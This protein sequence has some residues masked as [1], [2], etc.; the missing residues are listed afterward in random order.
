MPPSDMEVRITGKVANRGLMEEKLRAQGLSVAPPRQWEREARETPSVCSSSNGTSSSTSSPAKSSPVSVQLQHL[1]QMQQPQQQPHIIQSQPQPQ[2]HIHVLTGSPHKVEQPAARYATLEAVPSPNKTASPAFGAPMVVTRPADTVNGVRAQPVRVL[3]VVTRQQAQQQQQQQQQQSP[4]E[5]HQSPPILEVSPANPLSPGKPGRDAGSPSALGADPILTGKVDS[6]LSLPRLSVQSGYEYCSEGVSTP[7]ESPGRYVQFF[8]SAYDSAEDIR[9]KTFVVPA[10]TVCMVSSC[11]AMFTSARA[12]DG[13]HATAAGV[14]LA[15]VSSLFALIAFKV[16]RVSVKQVVSVFCFGCVLAIVLIDLMSAS[17]LGVRFW[18]LSVMLL[19]LCLSVNTSQYVDLSVIAIVGVSLAVERVEAMTRFGLYDAATFGRGEEIDVCNCSD[20]PCARP[21]FQ[22]ISALLGSMMTFV[23]DYMVTRGFARNMRKQKESVAAAVRL[24]EE[25]AVVLSHYETE[26]GKR[27]LHEHPDSAALPNRLGKALRMIVNNL[28]VYRR[29]LPPSILHRD[30][31]LDTEEMDFDLM[32]GSPDGDSDRENSDSNRSKGT[33][34]SD[35]GRLSAIVVPA[36][37]IPGAGGLQSVPS[38]PDLLFIPP[39][40][41]AESQH[42]SKQNKARTDSQPNSNILMT[43]MMSRKSAFSSSGKDD[44]LGRSSRSRLRAASSPNIPESDSKSPRMGVGRVESQLREFR[45]RQRN[46]ALMVAHLDASRDLDEPSLMTAI[47]VFVP[48]V[49]KQVVDNGGVILSISTSNSGVRVLATWNVYKRCPQQYNAS[50]EAV[51][52]AVSELSSLEEF[53]PPSVV[54]AFAVSAGPVSFANVGSDLAM[55]PVICGLPVQ[56][57][58]ALS[59]LALQLGCRALCDDR[60]YQHVRSDIHARPIDA[61]VMLGA[62]SDFTVYEVL[63]DQPAFLSE[64][65]SAFSELRQGNHAE[66]VA[67]YEHVLRQCIVPDKQ[68]ARL[69]KVAQGLLTLVPGGEAYCREEMKHRFQ[70]FKSE[71]SPTCSPPL[72]PL[73]SP[74]AVDEK[75]KKGPSFDKKEPVSTGPKEDVRS[76]SLLRREESTDV[77]KLRQHLEDQLVTGASTPLLPV[78]RGPPTTFSDQRQRQYHRS[79]TKLGRGAF[80]DVWLGMG[81]DGEMVAVKAIP[82]H[83]RQRREATS[84]KFSSSQDEVTYTG[85]GF[86]TKS[87]SNWMTYHTSGFVSVGGGGEVSDHD[88]D[89]PIK[90]RQR[91]SDMVSEVSLMTSLRH[92]NVVQYLGCAL[93]QLF[94]LIIME[95]IP[96]GSLAHVKEQFGGKLPYSCVHRYATDIVTGLVFI[97]D[98]SIVH[99]DLKPANVL[100][101]AEGQARLADFGASAELAAL[102]EGRVAGTPLYMAPE[103]ARG[104]AERKSDVWSF[105]V[106]LCELLTGKTPW[107]VDEEPLVFLYHLGM[108][109]RKPPELDGLL[110][111]EALRVVQVC[112]QQDPTDRPTAKQLLSHAFFLS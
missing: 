110:S 96:G 85:T 63:P 13:W 62:D 70:N 68:I 14:M 83:G 18:S 24:T 8:V 34:G 87:T 73:L 88:V 4:L 40:F 30:E 54:Y 2:Q 101:T 79:T 19:D 71:T 10:L 102:T 89:D 107:H 43:S 60:W 16:L 37:L 7:N 44:E 35:L 61:V 93:D 76:E 36:P 90:I 72:S 26:E 80:G 95:Y 64:Q 75:D 92:E 74:V 50:C 94:V 99:R 42:S 53:L 27:L 39:G 104:L 3:V 106:V 59:E 45:R 29:F 91:V 49:L 38:M 112:L 47:R 31:V 81:S 22:M 65:I 1:R 51:L 28:E 97:H 15:F 25:I 46:A 23:I 66:A 105:G 55:A 12:A 21:P 5:R 103:Q 56:R 77:R 69:R 67:K 6:N 111:G 86:H 58:W 98:N 52:E 109:K 108:G 41:D 82:I 100:A 20:P 48:V 32:S 78:D 84:K 57:C 11:W 33:H 9:H 17:R